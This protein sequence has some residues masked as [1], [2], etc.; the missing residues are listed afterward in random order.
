VN[1]TT[2]R[3]ASGR[4]GTGATS[5]EAVLV[6]IALAA[7][8]VLILLL[9][10]GSVLLTRPLWVDEWFTLLVAS[11]A[12]PVDVIGDLRQGADGGASLFH[13]LVWAMRAPTGSVSPFLLRAMSLVFVWSA[14]LLVY[15]VLRRR[16]GRDASI[17]GMLAVGSHGLVAAHAFEGRFY[18]L[19]LFCCALCA[20]SLSRNQQGTRGRA[21][22]VAI[23]AILLCTSH[24]YGIFSLALMCAAVLASYG[25]RWRD[26]V[27][28]CAPAA[29][30]LVALAAVSPL[31]IGQRNAVTVDTWIPGFSL[32][33][34]TGLSSTFWL[35]R[36]PMIAAAIIV[37]VVIARWRRDRGASVRAQAG[38]AAHDAGSVALLSLALMPLVLALLSVAGQPSML[39]RYAIPAVLAW[40]PVVA[41]AMEVAGRWTARVF[42]IVLMGFWFVSFTREA[43]RKRAFALGV[44]QEAQ[45]IRQAESMGLPVVFQSLHTMYPSVAANRAR[46]SPSVF[47]ELPDSTLDALFPRSSRWYQLNKGIRLERDFARVHADRFGFPTLAPQAALDTTTRFLFMASDARLPRGVNDVTALARAAFPR[48]QIVRVS[49]NLLLLERSRPLPRARSRPGR[50]TSR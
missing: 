48:H 22:L 16:F 18:A 4:A 12:S 37:V 11:H 39:S 38:D 13:L 7:L 28:V 32:G 1:T 5:D 45:T 42:A 2:P 10:K 31:A 46:P 14:L 27:R 21:A 3:R 49:E 8:T 17:A 50:S 33:Q 35:A 40:G 19:W 24:W 25:S 44:E 30:G 29:V 34:L 15:L 47:L 43:G 26:G 23:A 41:F 20:W 9:S 36:V 6:A